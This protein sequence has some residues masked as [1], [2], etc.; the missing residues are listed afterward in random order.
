MNPANEGAKE[1]VALKGQSEELGVL[2]SLQI[3]TLSLAS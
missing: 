3:L 2:V 1:T